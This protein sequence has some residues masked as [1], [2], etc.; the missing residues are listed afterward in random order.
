MY[1]IGALL[2][3]YQLLNLHEVIHHDRYNQYSIVHHSSAI[4]GSS[5][6]EN[7]IRVLPEGDTTPKGKPF[8]HSLMVKDYYH[9][10]LFTIEAAQNKIPVTADLVRGSNARVMKTTGRIYKTVLGEIDASQG[11]FRKGNVSAG[12]SYFVNYDKVEPYTLSLT[13][14]LQASMEQELTVEEKLQLS[15]STHFYF[16][17]YSSI[18]WWQW[19]NQ[20]AA[21]EFHPAIFSS[22]AGNCL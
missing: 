14:K 12:G 10:L 8:E 4:E 13:K 16:G 2:E 15:F 1:N 5:V 22:A 20:Q 11:M 6:T 21:R 17:F 3:D 9:A 18:L 7:E 19:L